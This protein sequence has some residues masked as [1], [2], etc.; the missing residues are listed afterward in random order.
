MSNKSKDLLN[1][2]LLNNPSFEIFKEWN[3]KDNEKIILMKRK[4]LNSYIS[5]RLYRKN[6]SLKINKLIMD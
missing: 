6:P 2:Y 1:R 5:Y 4:F 3:L